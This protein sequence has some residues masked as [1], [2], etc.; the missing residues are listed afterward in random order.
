LGLVYFDFGLVLLAA[1][2]TQP[3]VNLSK[4]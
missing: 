3:P 1:A 4:K 2:R